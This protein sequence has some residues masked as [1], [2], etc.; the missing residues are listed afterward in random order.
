[1]NSLRETSS[2]SALGVFHAKDWSSVLTMGILEELLHEAELNP[3][4]K[5][6]LCLHPDPSD[7]LQVTYLA[8]H[9][10]Y[11]DK[12]HCHPNRNEV[13]IPVYGYAKLSFYDDTGLVIRTHK[14]E[15]EKPFAI[16]TPPGV[17]HSVEVLSDSFAMVEI[18]TGPFSS[19]STK[20]M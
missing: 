8:F 19:S 13:L 20:Y 9:A 1:M 4:N 18:G 5:A 12:I 6:R 16:A 7:I 3:N 11:K 14:M 10:P 17:W 15:G 2:E